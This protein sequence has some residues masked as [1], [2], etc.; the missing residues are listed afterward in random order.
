V[1]ILAEAF[2][3]DEPRDLGVRGAVGPQGRATMITVNGKI[4]TIEPREATEPAVEGAPVGPPMAQV[5]ITASEG[6]STG[7][8]TLLVPAAATGGLAVGPC[9]IM[10]ESA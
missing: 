6:E 2:E 8:V 5:V 9:R 3:A 1:D 4:D 10:I 7:S